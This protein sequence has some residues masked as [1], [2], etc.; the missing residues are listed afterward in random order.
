VAYLDNSRVT[1]DAI[2]TKKGR[3]L[4]AKGQGFNITQFAVADDEV[5]YSLWTT[6]HPLG[7]NFYG[8]IIENMPLV[9]AS[10]DETQCM[11]FK[12]VTLPR[13]T[14]EIPVIAL[15]FDNIIL[16]AGQ[17][18]AFP[19]RPSTTQGLNGSGF[20]Y[21]AVLFDSTAAVLVGTGLAATNQNT[22]PGFLGDTQSANA[23]VT[24][25]IEFTLTPKDVPAQ[26][27]TS[28]TIVG[29]ETGAAITIPVIIKPKPTV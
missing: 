27:N 5:D 26:V 19:I 12:L 13:G 2:L 10:P 20:G 14:K 22:A 3:E 7:S 4:L 21:T 6:S 11:R 25:G 8:A 15:G 17:I 1:V 9:E 24:R 28:L 16:T 18:N 23:V 29:N